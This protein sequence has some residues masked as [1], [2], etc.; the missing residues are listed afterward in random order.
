MI[1]MSDCARSCAYELLCVM[2]STKDRHLP[3]P[4]T[5]SGRLTTVT[6]TYD[7]VPAPRLCLALSIHGSSSD[8]GRPQW[9]CSTRCLTK[10]TA[11]LLAN[12]LN[13]MSAGGLTAKRDA[14]ASDAS[15]HYNPRKS[16]LEVYINK[17]E[18]WLIRSSRKC[19]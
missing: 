2:L 8:A 11:C 9:P 3:L 5:L 14:A 19:T 1:R 6:L 10:Q 4:H 17:S 18:V 7:M 16:S 12:R 15:E 13:M